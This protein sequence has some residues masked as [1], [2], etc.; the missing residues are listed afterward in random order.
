MKEIIKLPA[1]FYL[2][3]IRENKPF[4]LARFGDGEVLCM[5]LA[6]HWL[7][8]NCDG[9]KFLPEL[10]EPM[11]QIFRNQYPY[12]HCLLDCSFDL[13]GEYF[14][15]FIEE[16]CPDMPF[17]DGEIWQHLSFSD[18]IVEL[19]TSIAPY[20]PVFVGGKHLLEVQHMNGIGN[21]ENIITNSKDAFKQFNEIVET[22]LESHSEGS[23]FFAFSCGFASKPIIDTL[24]PYIGHDSFLID[25]GS[26]FDPYCGILSRGGMK[27]AGKAKFQ[28][29]TSYKL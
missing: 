6:P 12:Y 8:E 23:R 20:N 22:V 27:F 2:E 16:T 26:V 21:I 9:S 5:Q 17:Y 18:R 7:K 3:R 15:K 24:F 28:P 29:Y 14:K 1:E 13:N 25:F 10:V 19:T 4:T 11:R